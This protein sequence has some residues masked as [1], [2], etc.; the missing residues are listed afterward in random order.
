MKSFLETLNGKNI[1]FLIGSGA[2][3]PMYPTLG[4]AL[5]K[6]TFEDFVTHEDLNE[7]SRLKLYLYYFLKI[8][9][10]M[11]E[12]IEKNISDNPTN[13][14]VFDNYKKFIKL[15]INILHTE[16]NERPKRINIFTTNYD[17]LFETAF[18]NTNDPLSYFN[19][20]SKGFIKRKISNKNFYLNVTQSGYGDKYRREI[21]TINLFKMHGSL[22]WE[23][24][25]DSPEIVVN[26]ESK[27]IEK[28]NDELKSGD[29]A[30]GENEFNLL[31]RLEDFVN[32]HNG[33]EES[34]YSDVNHYLS[35]I[36]IDDSILN[37]FEEKYNKLL[38]I[39]PDK[40]KFRDTVLDEHYFQQIRSFSYE[41]EK[42][43]SILIVFGFSFAD[44]HIQSVFE[45]SILNPT[46]D[47]YIICY[48]EETI[49]LFKND[50]FKN[51][52]NITYLPLQT[53]LEDGS[54]LNG[55]F[56]YLNNLL[57]G[58]END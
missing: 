40:R 49:Q 51:H 10:P 34:I 18:D 15:I 4:F 3:V 48:S 36:I 39:N 14:L 25:I 50:K 27:L 13:K 19:D 56:D 42:P 21:P 24:D 31:N 47:V 41:L 26:Y 23:Q 30:I 32:K 38:I 46:L 44:E 53:T 5:N 8:I 45:R 37:T 9:A 1:N 6:P 55:N 33:S 28:L 16:S 43:N 54:K 22:S 29:S 12:P 20:G 2:S 35:E 57:G 52:Q 58:L 11:S 7:Q 17:M